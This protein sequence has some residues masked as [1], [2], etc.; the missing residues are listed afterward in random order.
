MVGDGFAGLLKELKERSGLSYGAL[1]KRLH[2]SA[3]TLH[4]YVNGDAVPVDYAPVERFARL[5]K[6]TPEELVELHRRWVLA[7]AA[8]RKQKGAAAAAAVAAAAEEKRKP[9]QDAEPADRDRAPEPEPEQT[10]KQQ[11]EPEPEPA[12]EPEPA[13]QPEPVAAAAPDRPEADPAPRP[14]WRRRRIALAGGGVLAVVLTSALAVGL[15]TGGDDGGDGS[16][17]AAAEATAGAGGPGDGDEGSGGKRADASAS[18]DGGERDSG[19]GESG[20]GAGS[21]GG[22]G[23]DAA[24]SAGGNDGAAD[25]GTVT[26]P[27]VVAEPYYWDDPC[28]QH[29]LVNQ[30]PSQ[31]PP[32]PVADEARGWVSALGGVTGGEH[33]VRLTVQGSGDHTI[34][35]EDLHVR[36]VGRD[37]PLPWNDYVMATD[38]CGGGVQTRHFDLD[39]DAGRPGIEPA[40]GEED[41]PYQVSEDD[42]EV[43]YVVARTQEHD[44]RWFL[45]LEWSSGGERGTVRIDDG[46][47]PFRTSANEDRPAYDYPLGFNDRWEVNDGIPGAPED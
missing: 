24:G 2:M 25:G 20:A 4:R 32:P 17:D 22:G 28:S 29:Y 40:A 37:D 47:Q 39:L 26:P 12:S 34:V 5:C 44:V 46:G 43:Y 31:V 21:D 35:L 3:S 38:G 10:P 33:W 23:E 42:P 16:G 11:P 9:E 45:E 41:F 8:R 13:P 30:E 19:D 7:D 27:T 36:V 6:A 15:L 1:G 14:P 18:Q